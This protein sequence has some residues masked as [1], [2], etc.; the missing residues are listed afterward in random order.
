M[1]PPSAATEAEEMDEYAV[2]M[3]EEAARGELAF[4]PRLVYCPRCRV[5][6]EPERRLWVRTDGLN[7][8]RAELALPVYRLTCGHYGV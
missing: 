5:D 1:F 7:I 6:A 8:S 3:A 2:F 4:C